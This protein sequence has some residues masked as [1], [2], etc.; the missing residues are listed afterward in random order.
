MSKRAGDGR[1]VHLVRRVPAEVRAVTTESAAP[2]GGQLKSAASSLSS[3]CSSTFAPSVTSAGSMNSRGLWL[4]PPRLGTKSCRRGRGAPPPARRAGARRLRL[5]RPLYEERVHVLFE[6]DGLTL[7]HLPDVREVRTQALARGLVLTAV[8]AEHDHRVPAVNE[9][10][11]RGGEAFP[12]RA[13]PH[14]D[15]REHGVRAGVRAAVGEAFGL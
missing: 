4:M 5:Q 14:E 3:A 1:G 8:L 11:G 10:F 2:G 13:E 9:L 7:A 12:L 6:A 15:A